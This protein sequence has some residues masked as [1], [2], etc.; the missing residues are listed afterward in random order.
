MNIFAGWAKI[1]RVG[2]LLP[3]KD[4]GQAFGTETCIIRPSLHINYDADF[5]N[6]KWTHE[7]IRFCKFLQFLSQGSVILLLFSPN[8]LRAFINQIF[9]T[10][11]SQ[12]Y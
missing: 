6:L 2:N 1:V 12:L 8:F 7:E 3:I 9:S 4:Y 11:I 10:F 5:F